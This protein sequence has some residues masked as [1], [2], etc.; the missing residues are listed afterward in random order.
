MPT[1]HDRERLTVQY[2]DA[3]EMFSASVKLLRECNGYT[4]RTFADQHRATELARLHSENAR[5]TLELH[6]HEHGC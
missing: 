5:V 6:R 4:P 1:C 2:H 3:V